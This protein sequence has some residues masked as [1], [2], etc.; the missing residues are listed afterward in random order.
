MAKT[1]EMI[2]REALQNLIEQAVLHGE[3]VGSDNWYSPDE[4]RTLSQGRIS[5]P[6]AALISFMT[7]VTALSLLRSNEA[8]DLFMSLTGMTE[9]HFVSLL[10]T[11]K[12]VSP[13][14]IQMRGSMAM[15]ALSLWCNLTKNLVDAATHTSEQDRLDERVRDLTNAMRA[16]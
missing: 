8:E 4:L 10:T 1:R 7:P 2:E 12:A 14:E 13:A 5:A 9:K 16:A 11:D 3:A 15:G 6:D